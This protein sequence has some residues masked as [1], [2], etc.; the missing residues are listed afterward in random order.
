MSGVAWHALSIEGV[1]ARVASS[2]EG[3]AEAEVEARRARDGANVLAERPSAR[4]LGL[5]LRQ[6][7]SVLVAV[8]IAAGLVAAALGETLDAGAILAIV[9][10]NAAIGFVQEYRAERA[11]A[12]LRRLPA[13]RANV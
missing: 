10:L 9:A 12:A 1:L 5:L 7:R 2:P 8:L 6:F 3:I 4:P 11:L 13:P